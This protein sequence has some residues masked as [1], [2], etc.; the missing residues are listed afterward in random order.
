VIRCHITDRRLAGGTEALV[1]IISRNLMDGVDLVQI[2]E[3]DLSARDLVELVERV[4]L[5]PNPHGSRILVNS[6]VDVAMGCGAAGV[7][8]PGH[9]FPVDR[10]RRIAPAHFLVGVSCHIES[11]LYEAEAA[12]ADFALL[13]PV[14]VSS[15]K[16]ETQ[17]P[18]GLD[19][20]ERMVAKV[21]IPVLALGGISQRTAPSCVSAGAAGV[22]GIS[23]FQ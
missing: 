11:E 20:L 3:K 23:M 4:L 6:R 8:L 14:F 2:R 15:S 5:L 12:G 10:V 22:A 1:K 19:R 17:P 16:P 21:R 13:S 18:L 9:S 7:H